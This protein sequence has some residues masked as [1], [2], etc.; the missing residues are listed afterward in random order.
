MATTKFDI[1]DLVWFVDTKF[2]EEDRCECCGTYKG[3]KAENM[4]KAVI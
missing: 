4:L 3:M 2:F 1:D